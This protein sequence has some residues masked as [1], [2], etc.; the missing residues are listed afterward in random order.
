M[1]YIPVIGAV[2][3][4]V[5][6]IIQK[7][8]LK[9]KKINTKIYLCLE[10]LVI[11]LTML[12]F[13]YFFWELDPQAFELTNLFIFGL[14]VLFSIIANL[15]LFYSLKWE[16]V[17][18]LEPAKILEP[19][20]IILLAILFSFFFSDLYDR[21]F[22]VIIPALIAAV[23][24]VFSHI[25]KHHL[26]FNKYFIAMIISSFFFALEL[27]ISKLILGLYSPLSF[28]FLRSMVVLIMSLAIFRPDFS[29]ANKKDTKLWL[30]VI[31]IVW[32]I[33]RVSVYWGFQ[34]LGVI[35]T[36][37]IIMLA[38]IFI[39]ILAWKFL[40]EKINWKNIVAAFIIVGCVLY[41]MFN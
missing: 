40:K 4:A 30:A 2:A 24:L 14:V 26:D 1:F 20:F 7:K 15:F 8:I 34:E 27:V 31:G 6:T 16:K 21:N 39:Y 13:I 28:Y 10:F 25:K 17:S 9:N 23:T 41:A 18:N 12:P 11:T 35:S 38:P 32:V 33:Y 19:L 29:A 5:G 37:L 36:A 22:N 3:L